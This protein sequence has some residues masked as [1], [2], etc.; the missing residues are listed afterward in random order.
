MQ[1]TSNQQF[2]LLAIGLKLMV[3]LISENMPTPL[4]IVMLHF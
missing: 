3:A 1:P 2:V 4:S